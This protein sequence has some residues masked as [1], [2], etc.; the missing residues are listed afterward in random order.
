LH[1]LQDLHLIVELELL[2]I[3]FLHSL[4]YLHAWNPKHIIYNCRLIY[5]SS[6]LFFLYIPKSWKTTDGFPEVFESSLLHDKHM[7]NTSTS[8]PVRDLQI[9]KFLLD[10]VENSRESFYEVTL[11]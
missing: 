2:K 10:M 6:I 4:L 1:Q 9:E 5:S 3:L 11:S 7:S 8:Y